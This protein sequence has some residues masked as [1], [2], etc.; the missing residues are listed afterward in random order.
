[1]NKYAQERALLNPSTATNGLAGHH[2]VA[3]VE[4][5][6]MAGNLI[7]A[8]TAISGLNFHQLAKVMNELIRERNLISASIV[9]SAL[10]DR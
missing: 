9:I 4:N 2:I 1:M 8:S 3:F 10:A 6:T 7:S 5:L